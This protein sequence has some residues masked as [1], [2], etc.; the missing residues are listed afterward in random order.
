M[1]KAISKNEFSS[2]VIK[3]NQLSLVKFK[4][5]WSGPCQIIEPVYRDVAASYLG[6]VNFFTVDVEQEKGLDEIYGVMELPTI[7]IFKRGKVVDH[8]KGLTSKNTLVAKIENAL[9]DN[10]Y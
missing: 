6:V 1:T 7:L 3:S 5:E 10:S 8:T 4:T 9:A 2:M